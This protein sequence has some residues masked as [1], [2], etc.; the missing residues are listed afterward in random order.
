MVS[1]GDVRLGQTPRCYLE[2]LKGV[3]QGKRENLSLKQICVGRDRRQ[4][5]VTGYDDHI[6]HCHA[7]IRW[8]AEGF[9]IED[10]SSRNGALVSGDL[11]SEPTLLKRG[12][13]I[14]LG[15]PTTVRFALTIPRSQDIT[16]RSLFIRMERFSWFISTPNTGTAQEIH[17][18][19]ASGGSPAHGACRS[20]APQVVTNQRPRRCGCLLR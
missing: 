9:E 10:L 4:S 7:V 14:Q 20:V 3:N 2:S 17:Q 15:R 12:D 1:D 18:D 6:S 13:E 19:A 16:I 5:Q 8:A 11:I